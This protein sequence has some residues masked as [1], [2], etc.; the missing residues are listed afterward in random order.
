MKIR[1]APMMQAMEIMEPIIF[2]SSGPTKVATINCGTRK[3]TDAISVSGIMPFN[4]FTP[5]PTIMTMKN[6]DKN[7]SSACSPD[8]SLATVSTRSVK[9]VTEQS[10]CVGTPTEPKQV[11]VELTTRQETTEATGFSPAPTI[12]DAGMATAVPKPAMPSMKLPKPQPISSAR[13]RESEEMLPSICLILSI[14]PVST[15]RL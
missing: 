2:G 8:A 6:G 14:A 7:V 10:V 13:T 12:I 9:P 5:P 11:G 4:A 1:V 3:D 15:V